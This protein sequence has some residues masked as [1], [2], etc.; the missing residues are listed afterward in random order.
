MPEMTGTP[1]KALTDEMIAPR[2]A[3]F[4]KLRDYDVS[5]CHREGR[6]DRGISDEDQLAFATAQ[7]RAIYTFNVRDF[8]RLHHRWQA[9]GRDHAGIIVSEDLNHDLTEM[10][11]R[12]R[13]HM[14]TVEARTQRN[15]IWVLRPQAR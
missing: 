12:L 14:D 13:V 2:L 3:D 9:A 1:A 4:L 15:Q 6:A 11:R 5:S 7:D 10:M 8:R